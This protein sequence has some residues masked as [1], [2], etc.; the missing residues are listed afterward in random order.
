MKKL[1]ALTLSL[2]M[3]LGLCGPV[4]AAEPVTPTPPEWI[5]A[6]DYL[7]FPGDEV[8]EPEN[9]AK[10][11]AMREEARNG[12]LMPDTD[13]YNTNT[14]EDSSAG[15]HY[16]MALVR[17]K[18]A[19][20]AGSD[21]KKLRNT[22]YAVGRAFQ[23]AASERYYQLGMEW[24]ELS[25]R[26]SIEKYRAWAIYRFSY[27][28]NWKKSLN[29]VLDPLGLSLDDFLAGQYMYLM[30]PQDKADMI[31]VME[32]IELWM[33]DTELKLDV[34]PEVKN[35]RTMVPVR[36]VGEAIGADVEWVQ[37]K[38]QVVMTRAGSTVTMTL[39]S[40][41]AD[42]D[43]GKVEMDVAPYAVDG[44]T[45]LPARYV[46][47]FFGQKVDWDGEKRRVLIT[48]NKSVAGD[49]N[50]ESWALA[51]GA[52]RG[53]MDM[54]S[55]KIFGQMHRSSWATKKIRERLAS[56]WGSG[57]DRE[58]LI[59]LIQRM[60]PHGHNDDFQ[61]AAAAANDLTE[62]EMAALIAFSSG[63]DQ[64]MWPYT[65]A[66]SEK[67]G[68]KGILA[69]DLSRMANLVQWGYTA[70]FLTYEEA[71]ELIEPAARMAH[72]TFSSWEEFY[73]NYLDGYNWW[74]RNDV[75]E[76]DLWTVTRGPVCRSMLDDPSMQ[77]VLDDTLFTTGV[78]P[79]PD[80][81]G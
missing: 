73:E 48:E 10:V 26:L 43:G 54:D 77:T 25:Y 66:V 49:S 55:P 17:I 74:A 12:M 79:L 20:N 46:A 71:L 16:E 15:M 62:D 21:T 47:E 18:Y 1:L 76:K 63:A 58:G 40:T 67:W 31:A 9:W 37:D 7:I 8:Y 61:V 2:V 30:D 28:S 78:I 45:L 24:D 68:D 64:Y 19:L 11:E 80:K 44:R 4:L 65:R 72:E 75:F 41:T 32:A 39:D 13:G 56:D 81:E 38:Q 69:W 22:F 5:N 50:L 60:T 36:A 59:A 27:A 3:T 57:S 70:G 51:M 33:D 6:E 23:A 35:Q 53:Q 42:I 14:W 52:M 29:S 34:P